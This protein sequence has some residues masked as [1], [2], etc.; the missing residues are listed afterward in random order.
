M[1]S[2]LAPI[3]VF[4]YNRPGHL[5]QCLKSLRENELAD[6]SILYIYSD[7][8]KPNASEKDI[9]NIE[10]TRKIIRQEQ[11]CK[12]IVVIE[13]KE[14]KGLAN[15]IIDGVTTVVNKHG[16]VI[17]LEDDLILSTHFLDYMNN[18]LDSYENIENIYS[19][20]GFMFPVNIKEHSTFLLPYTSTWGW[21]TWK[22]K[23]SVFNAQINEDDRNVLR[24]DPSLK[25][26][27]DLSDYDY[28]SMLNFSNNSWGI[29]WYY[30]VFIRNGL[31]VF[32]TVS[33]VKNIGNDGSGT[34]CKNEKDTTPFSKSNSVTIKIE[35]KLN[36]KY[37]SLY[38][39]LFTKPKKSKL[40]KLIHK[41][42]GN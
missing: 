37:L 11:W 29:K 34:N 26:R 4:T 33:L 17:V 13:E 40:K 38:Q 16:K 7:G 42:I 19:I 14:N 35:N 3:V 21:A 9:K 27:F 23:W 28:T 20:N 32:P 1:N 15:S 6:K 22:N 39:E 25:K 2:A 36:L 31:N 18:A 5:L 8:Q 30:S 41:V 12:E 24:N 10:E